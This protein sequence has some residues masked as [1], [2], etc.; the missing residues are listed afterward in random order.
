MASRS[1]NSVFADTVQ[2]CRCATCRQLNK[3]HPGEGR[4]L[5]LRRITDAPAVAA[6]DAS[7]AGHVARRH[8][9]GTETA[10]D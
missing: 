2:P 3:L 10:C 4:Q 5:R 7:P 1:T 8:L 9:Q 6:A